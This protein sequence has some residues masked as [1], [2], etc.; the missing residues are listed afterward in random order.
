MNNI[1]PQPNAEELTDLQGI[2]LGC[3]IH[4][5]YIEDPSMEKLTGHISLKIKEIFC[6]SYKSLNIF[7]SHGL[8]NF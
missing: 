5:L 3:S 8:F 6:S 1:G 7:S 4:I 2:C